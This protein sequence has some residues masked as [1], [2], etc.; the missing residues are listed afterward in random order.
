MDAEIRFAAD[1]ANARSRCRCESC[2]RP[3]VLWRC[4][5][6][7]A[8]LCDL[9]GVGVPEATL[10]G[11]QTVQV[12]LGFERGIPAPIRYRR[13]LVESDTLL[14]MGA[15]QADPNV[16][17]GSDRCPYPLRRRVRALDPKRAEP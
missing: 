6:R 4:G 16:A 13:Y 8:T 17:A 3:A 12:V 7:L 14:D 1:L 5:E 2:S 10:P 15:T 9:H 11:F